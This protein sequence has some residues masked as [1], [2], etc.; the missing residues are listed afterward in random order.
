MPVTNDYRDST[1]QKQL[2]LHEFT[3]EIFGRAFTSIHRIYL[4]RE[5]QALWRGEGFSFRRYIILIQNES[6]LPPGEH[7]YRF[8]FSLPETTEQVR[9]NWHRY[10][11]WKDRHPFPGK[12]SVHQIPP[13]MAQI[14]GIQ[15]WGSTAA[16]VEYVIIATVKKGPGEKWHSRMPKSVRPFKVAA[17]S[18]HDLPRESLWQQLER[19]LQVAGG[20]A[21]I[22]CRIPQVL[23]QRGKIPIYMKADRPGLVLQS[24]KIKLYVVYLVR[25]R[26]MIWPEKR[27]KC[28]HTTQLLRCEM[29]L[30]LQEEFALVRSRDIPDG[31]PVPF[32]TFNLACLAHWMEIKYRVA[33][34]GS[35]GEIKDIMQNISVQVQCWKAG[36]QMLQVPRKSV[37]GPD[38]GG[39][40]GEHF[41]EEEYRA[42]RS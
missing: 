16:H 28:T 33:V 6:I 41:T 15:R 27:T 20:A 38:C 31:I 29:R 3:I 4:V 42:R 36:E 26:H 30:P 7:H 35:K 12:N 37:A 10:V 1:L 32:V 11:K 8:K 5:F 34:P 39:F 13:S 19:T 14:E 23:T 9:S 21:K 40:V 24:L 17:C 2:S 22:T 18:R 25:A